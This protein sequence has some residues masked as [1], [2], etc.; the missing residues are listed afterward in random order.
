MAEKA[1][2]F[3]SFLLLACSFSNI[4]TVLVLFQDVDEFF[5]SEK[6]FLVEYNM[7]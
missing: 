5:E 1:L 4:K 2:T 6:K 3:P 7:K